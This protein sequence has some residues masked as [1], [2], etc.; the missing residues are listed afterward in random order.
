MEKTIPILFHDK[1]NCCGCGACMNVC[2]VGAVSM[3]ED[4]CGYIYPKIDEKKCIRCGKCKSVCAFQSRQEMNEP[5]ETFAAVSKNKVRTKKSA[6]GGIFAAIAEEFLSKGGHVFGA[7]F[8][9]DWGISHKCIST[10]DELHV[11]QGSKYAQ[12]NTLDTFSQ[13]KQLLEK[14]KRVLYSGTPCQIAGL[15]AFLGKEYDNLLTIDIICHGVPSEK[16]LKD[17]LNYLSTGHKDKVDNFTFRDKSIGWGKNGSIVINDKRVILWESASSYL[18]YFAEGWLSRKNCYQ[19]KYASKHRPADITLGDY[20]GIEKQ[21]PEYLSSG[22]DES[23][24]ISVVIANTQKGLSV[25]NSCSSIEMKQS[26]FE[27]AAVANHQLKAPV[28][29][30]KRD[31]IVTL[32]GEQGWEALEVRFKKNIG[33]KRYSSQIKSMIPLKLKR[34]LKRRR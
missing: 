28:E 17:Y 19:C 24:G 34:W 33:I 7:A 1:E 13:A 23:E 21:H 3:S 9:N 22:W 30:G 5:V 12:S 14:G 18:Y 15:K 27:K 20:W 29:K 32:Y 6:S 2:P 11:L 25:L 10:V 8:T 16:M 26:T 4:K 31:E